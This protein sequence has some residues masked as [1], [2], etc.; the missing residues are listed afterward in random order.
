LRLG[1]RLIRSKAGGFTQRRYPKTTSAG[2]SMSELEDAWELALADAQMRAR[3][4]GRSDIAEYLTV[5]RRN[6]LLRRTAIDWLINE[7][8]LLAGQANRAG[9]GIQIQQTDPHRFSRRNATM[10]GRQV[11]LRRGV[12][13]LTIE[14]GWP[15]TPRDG[16]VRGGGLACANIKHYG[17]TRANAELL[18]T[19]LADGK[20]HWLIADDETQR[21]VFAEE[22]LRAHFVTFLRDD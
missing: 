9:A 19:P 21:T 11:T 16:I 18:L 10:V 2:T 20:P 4:S 14:C 5:R 13:E 12:R 15:R 1:V 8:I 17:R 7:V 3:V 6:D 22:T